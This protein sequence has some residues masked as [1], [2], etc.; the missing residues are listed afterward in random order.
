MPTPRG[1]ACRDLADTTAATDS[2]EIKRG[3]KTMHRIIQD[4]ADDDSRVLDRLVDGELSELERQELLSAL[5]DE[6][7]GWRRCALAFL[8][9]QT[10][11]AD[12][13][14]FRDQPSEPVVPAKPAA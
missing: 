4:F 5:D 12:L 8:E 11:G 14:S 3:K 13:K 2:Q 6:P 7:A 9:A 10:W 1:H